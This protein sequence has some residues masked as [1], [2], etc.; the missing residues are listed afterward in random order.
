[1]NTN[2]E[3][4][5]QQT[6]ET[7]H[8]ISLIGMFLIMFSAT[9][10]RADSVGIVMLYAIFFIITAWP[11]LKTMLFF[12]IIICALVVILPFLAPIA[13][14]LMVI[15]F[16]LRIHFILEN[17]RAVVAGLG[18]YS[19]AFIACTRDGQELLYIVP[20]ILMAIIPNTLINLFGPTVFLM[21]AVIN[22]VLAAAFLHKVLL[23]LY[24]Y[25]YS[26]ASALAIMGSVPLVII[27]MILPFLKVAG[28]HGFFDGAHTG[29]SADVV[30]NTNLVKPPPPSGYHNVHGYIRSGPNGPETVHGYVR[31]NPDGFVENNLSYHEPMHQQQQSP[32]VEHNNQSISKTVDHIYPMSTSD[33]KHTGNTRYKILAFILVGLGFIAAIIIHLKKMILILLFLVL[34]CWVISKIMSS[35]SK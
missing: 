4:I 24:E 9:F 5:Q 23:W 29:H 8:Q 3:W 11:M 1:M 15:L 22:G 30:H 35:Q 26:A 2:N 32:I 16:F 25:K 20:K 27:A 18:V 31:S 19:T 34:C 33:E 10:V 28:A 12:S 17:W 6:R 14:I 13:F 7:I 21:G